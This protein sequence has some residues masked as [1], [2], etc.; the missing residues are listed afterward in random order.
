MRSQ[1]LT[2]DTYVPLA[3]SFIYQYSIPAQKFFVRFEKSKSYNPL[4]SYSSIG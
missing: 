3:N 2:M 1:T 4:E